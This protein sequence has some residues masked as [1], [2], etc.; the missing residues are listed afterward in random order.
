[1]FYIKNHFSYS[2]ACFERKKGQDN[3]DM[4]FSMDFNSQPN[5]YGN[6]SLRVVMDGVSTEKGGRAV[7]IAF[8]AICRNLAGELAAASLELNALVE[9]AYTEEQED[10]N[11]RRID[12]LLHKIV[13]GSFQQTNDILRNNNC[14][15]TLSVAIFFNDWLFT[16]NIGDSPIYLINLNKTPLQLQGIFTCQTVAQERIDSGRMSEEEAINSQYQ[17]QVTEILGYCDEDDPNYNMLDDKNINWKRT[18]IPLNGLLLMG[19]DG[20][21]SY[22]TKEAMARLV[23]EN[24]INGLSAVCDAFKQQ[25]RAAGGE[26]DFTLIIDEI[27]FC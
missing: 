14:M 17:S 25:V 19:S 21:L 27:C 6:F 7:K 3:W 11:S 16:A 18:D 2:D 22:Q 13:L 4:C 20:A 23:E 5:S 15:T 8:P 26:D 1:M 10:E 9:E 24:L 12:D